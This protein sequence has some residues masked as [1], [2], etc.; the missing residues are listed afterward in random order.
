MKRALTRTALAASVVLVLLL[1]AAWTTHRAWAPGMIV[2]APYPEGMPAQLPEDVHQKVEVA[3]T[4][5]RVR[6]WV[7]DPVG[8]PRGTVLMLHGIHD[9][10]LRL[11]AGARHHAARGY[12]AVA[13]DSR[14]HGESSGAY[15]TYGVEES[16]DL[17][18][19]VDEL[20]RRK[21]LARPL[22]VVGS[23]YGAAT[24]LQHAALDARVDKV[25]ALAPFASLRQVVGAYI[26]WL[27]GPPAR[28]IPVPVVDELVDDCA[29]QAGFDP[30]RA[31]PRCVA[32]QIRAAVLLIHSRDDERI[33]WQHSVEIR[34]A[35]TSR[36]KLLLVDGVNHAQ[37]GRGARVGQTIQEWLDA[38]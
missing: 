6:A 31:C 20:E 32:P 2:T 14:G 1:A 4:G 15:L 22:A 10:K 37:V 12:R 9:S 5:A 23:S 7:F 26:D 29:R 34:N 35:L 30:D 16:R 13:V 17:V 38:M 3:R 27:L 18:A 28:W 8:P 33:P 21:L 25:V 24:A 19:M 36:K 11:V